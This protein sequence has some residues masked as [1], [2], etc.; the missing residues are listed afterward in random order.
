MSAVLLSLL[1]LGSLPQSP[2][3]PPVRPNHI[4]QHGNFDPEF[5]RLARD[6]FTATA[7]LLARVE[8][9]DD[10]AERAAVYLV[11]GFTK[12][13]QSIPWLE[14]RLA[15]ADRQLILEYWLS[16]WRTPPLQPDCLQA[17]QWLTER[18]TWARFFVNLC[19]TA[20][21]ARTRVL[22]VICAY[23]HD[24]ATRTALLELARDKDLSP[25]D[26]LLSQ[27]YLLTHGQEVDGPR[28]GLATATLALTRP[29]W[30]RW[31]I[32]G[33]Q[34]LHESM[35]PALILAMG[36]NAP[37]AAGPTLEGILRRI[38]LQRGVTGRTQWQGWYRANSA[39]TRRTWVTAV[40]SELAAAGA[41]PNAVRP[42]LLALPGERKEWP[43][44][45]DAALVDIVRPLAAIPTLRPTLAEWIPYAY[46][47]ACHEQFAAL[48]REV[49]AGDQA[50]IPAML[51]NALHALFDAP[52]GSWDEYVT[53]LNSRV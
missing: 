21:T 20:P 24:P 38:T 22:E 51:V 44:R 5:V 30:L 9:S 42:V 40:A 32:Q 10:P 7:G 17:A 13:P 28:L 4:D 1:F 19:R 16:Q 31:E 25:E 15:G 23:F 53:R 6:R 43:D 33:Y 47:P 26:V 36:D 8:H 37:A 49:L 50:G 46:T 3:D 48:A 45:A 14:A 29:D 12:D 2:A 27:G 11:L 39:T 41:D 34:I 35:V 52:R 18:D